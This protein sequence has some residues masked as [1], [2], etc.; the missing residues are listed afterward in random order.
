[1]VHTSI[2]DWDIKTN[3]GLIHP[4]RSRRL[5]KQSEG[6]SNRHELIFVGPEEDI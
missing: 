5:K 3:W 2:P 1:L 4:E 6:A